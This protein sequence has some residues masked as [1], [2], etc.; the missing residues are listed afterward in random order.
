MNNLEKQAPDET[1]VI[2][3]TKAEDENTKTDNKRALL[4]HN[5]KKSIGDLSLELAKLH[6]SYI[7]TFYLLIFT[8]Y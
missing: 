6:V 2:E 5:K 3:E 8:Q 7:P 4:G 1:P